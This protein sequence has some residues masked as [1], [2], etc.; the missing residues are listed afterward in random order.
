MWKELLF[1]LTLL[2][3]LSTF[4]TGMAWLLTFIHTREKTGEAYHK[5]KP[6]EL[7]LHRCAWILFAL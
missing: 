3:G 2:L 5:A 6:R 4:G 7:K 1:A